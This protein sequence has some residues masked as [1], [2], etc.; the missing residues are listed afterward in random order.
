MA[1]VALLLASHLRA[2]PVGH[3]ASYSVLPHAITDVFTFSGGSVT[4]QTCCGNE[5]IG[6]YQR[7]DDGTWVWRSEW[8]T[9]KRVKHTFIVRPGVFRTEFIDKESPAKSFSL[10]R[11]LFTSIPL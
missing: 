3:F 6:N 9:K 7:G 5:L 2:V 4:W 10:R 1:G 8:G 11:R